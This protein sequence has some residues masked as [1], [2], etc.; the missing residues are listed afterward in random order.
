MFYEAS[1]A[2]FTY[3]LYIELYR[4]HNN[5]LY[6]HYIFRKFSLLKNPPSLFGAIVFLFVYFFE[7]VHVCRA[8][9][10]YKAAREF[11]Y[12]Q[13]QEIAYFLAFFYFLLK[14]KPISKSFRDFK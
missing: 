1:K 4:K 7:I 2:K 10:R 13:K 5:V 11:C 6:L 9:F 14:N 8:F 3:L 12:P